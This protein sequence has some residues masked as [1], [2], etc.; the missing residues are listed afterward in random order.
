VDVTDLV[1]PIAS[2]NWNELEL[3]MDKSTLD[4]NLDFLSNLDSET[5]VAILISNDNNCLEAGSLTGL[6]LLLDRHDLHGLVGELSLVSLEKQVNDL[7]LL[8]GNGVSIN[9]L[10][11]LDVVVLDESAKLGQGSPFLVISSSASGATTGTISATTATATT[12]TTSITE[13][14]SLSTTTFAAF[15]LSIRY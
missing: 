15:H 2:S 7:G 1:T 4:S 5:N 8:D 12:A 10:E 13:A 9:L 14:T 11:G 6:S 3:G